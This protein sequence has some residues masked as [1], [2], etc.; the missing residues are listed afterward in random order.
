MHPT[1]NAKLHQHRRVQNLASNHDT[2]ASV[3]LVLIA[4]QWVGK[5]QG[6]VEPRALK[7][8]PKP[9]PLLNR[10]RQLARQQVLEYGHPKNVK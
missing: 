3:L 6:R 8:R 10:P 2:D 7:R 1:R 4:Q 5:R 9:Y